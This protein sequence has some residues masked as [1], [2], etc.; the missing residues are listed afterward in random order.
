MNFL[1][2]LLVGAISGWLADQLWKGSGFGLLGNII[3]GILGG[4]FGGWLASQIG[5][6]ESGLVGQIL[7][8]AGG[9]WVL[10]FLISFIKK[11]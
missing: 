4:L 5:L 3:V 8:A 9:A 11:K 7:I 6:G 2:F 10:L 1:Y